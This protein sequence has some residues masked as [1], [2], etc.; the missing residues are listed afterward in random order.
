VAD[1][2]VPMTSPISPV[3]K[4]SLVRR[5]FS[6]ENLLALAICAILILVV[7]VTS[8]SAP[9]WIYQGF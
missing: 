2:R 1:V 4:P 6:R 9:R 8:D 5:I 3:E 7:I